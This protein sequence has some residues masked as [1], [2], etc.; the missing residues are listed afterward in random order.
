MKSIIVNI[1]TNLNSI[2]NLEELLPKEFETGNKMKE[3]G[4]LEHLFV[5]DDN[6][7]AV[8]VFKGVD[9]QKTKELVA[10]FPLFEYFDNIEYVNVD[11]QY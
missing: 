10:T 11:K 4:F 1:T 7:G 3:Q 8:L 5:K 2:P 9:L 6:T